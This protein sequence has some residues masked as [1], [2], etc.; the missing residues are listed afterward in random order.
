MNRFRP[1]LESPFVWIAGLAVACVVAVL[2]WI[3]PEED[4]E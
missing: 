3:A 4:R 2:L 1:I